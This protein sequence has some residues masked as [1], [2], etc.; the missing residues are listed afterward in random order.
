MYVLY[1]TALYVIEIISALQF[2][3]IV[4]LLPLTERFTFLQ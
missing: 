1:L 2:L 4:I 3:F